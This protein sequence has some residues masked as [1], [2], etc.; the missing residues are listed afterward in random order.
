LQL[1]TENDESLLSLELATM[2]VHEALR[3]LAIFAEV[4]SATLSNHR[5]AHP[6]LHTRQSK[7]TRE[8]NYFDQLVQLTFSK[9]SNRPL[10]V[11]DRSLPA[12]F[13]LCAPRKWDFQ[14]PI[15]HRDILSQVGRSNFPLY[16]RRKLD[17]EPSR[18]TRRS[19]HCEEIDARV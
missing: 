10:I 19:L 9:T 6:S 5:L 2:K 13:P 4:S 8:I 17:R 18:H 15:L 3:L 11:L 16:H 7:P 12:R 14:A 1:L